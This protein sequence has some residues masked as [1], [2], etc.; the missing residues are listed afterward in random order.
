MAKLRKDIILAAAKFEKIKKVSNKDIVNL[1]I[2]IACNLFT[3]KKGSVENELTQVGINIQKT[4]EKEGFKTKFYDFNNIQKVFNELKKDNVDLIFNVCERINNTS[5]LEPHA[6]SLLDILQ[7]P[8]TGSNPL[9]LALCIDKIKVKKLLDFH[10]IPTPRWDYVFEKT[11]KVDDSLRYPLIVKPA[12][13]DNSIGITNDSVVKN[14]KELQNRI[15]YVIDEIK[16]PALIEEYIEGDE[17]D[18]P[19]IGN[20]ENIRV[21]PLSRSI[22]SNLP[23]GYWHIFP[24]EAK[25][26]SESVFKKHIITEEPPKRINKGLASLISEIAIDTYNILDCHDYG[27]VEIKVDKN[28]NPYVLE[29][30]PNP[31]INIGDCFYRVAPLAGMNYSQFLIEIVK[32]AINRYQFKPPYYHLQSNIL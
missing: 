1:K 9:T 27:R 3:E 23:K 8:Y 13:T 4:L 21:L 7:I 18:V 31:S 30:N 28:N 20:N 16:S 32:L 17:Y 14:E 15:K 26:D 5:L 11:D 25:W 19:I 29:L 10:G 12:N 6:A 2:G 22:F 24:Y